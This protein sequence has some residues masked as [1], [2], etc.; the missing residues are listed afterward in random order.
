[1]ADIVK[2]QLRR[3][4]AADWTTNDTV[5]GAG[6]PGYETDTGKIKYGDGTTAWTS[7]AYFESDKHF[8]FTQGSPSTTWSVAHN[9]QKKPSVTVVDSGN[10]EVEGDVNHI[11]DNNLTITFSAAFSGK[12]YIN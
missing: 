3:G 9:L 6:E 2:I 8:L 11:D 7:L 5:L 12:A 1:M 4:T 10:N